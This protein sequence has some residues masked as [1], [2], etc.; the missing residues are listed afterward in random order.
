MTIF[1]YNLIFLIISIYILGNTIGY[2]VYEIKQF[3]NKF[4]GITIIVFS[5]FVVI[6]SNAMMWT[7]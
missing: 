3:N 5:I 6:F 4:G 1:I 7:N 2:A